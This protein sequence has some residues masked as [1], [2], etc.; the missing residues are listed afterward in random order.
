MT[1]GGKR[2]GSGRPKLYK[3]PTKTVRLPI[4]E[5]DSVMRFIEN[6]DFFKLPLYG[7]KVSAGF[8]SPADDY[9]EEYL[10]LNDLIKHPTT[11]FFV[12]VSG[13]SMKDAGINENDI[14]IVDR[15]LSPTHG[16][17]VIAVLQ[18]QLT[19]KRIHKENN[20]LFLMP[21]NTEFSPIEVKEEDDIHIWGVVTKVIHDM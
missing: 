16:K 18:G 1:R 10:N 12:R 8:P 3:S 5:I 17:I 7:S 11:T 14:L 13:H 4:D 19:V 9:I 20:K 15:S 21:A 2:Q 6:K